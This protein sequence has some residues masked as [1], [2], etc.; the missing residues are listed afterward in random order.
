MDASQWWA[1]V[2][3]VSE[4]EGGVQVSEQCRFCNGDGWYSETAHNPA[5]TGDKCVKPCPVEEQVICR[6]C[7]GTGREGD[8]ER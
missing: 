5:C 3:S 1:T 6:N 8:D 4:A 2:R 7:E